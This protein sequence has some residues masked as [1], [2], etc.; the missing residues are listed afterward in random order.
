MLKS[1]PRDNFLKSW[2]DPNMG[3][4]IVDK[5][6]VATQQNNNLHSEIV[7]LKINFKRGGGLYDFK[8]VDFGIY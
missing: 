6:T 7:N 4:N 3:G 8:N 5:V 2:H 1:V